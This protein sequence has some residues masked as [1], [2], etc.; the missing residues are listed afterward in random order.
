MLSWSYEIVEHEGFK[1]GRIKHNGLTEV[2]ADQLGVELAL[3]D[4]IKKKSLITYL[5]MGKL[6]QEALTEYFRNIDT[7]SSMEL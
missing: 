3:V 5:P 4:E 2:R 6:R 1:A 7:S